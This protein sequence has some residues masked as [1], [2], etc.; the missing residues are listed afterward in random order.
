MS[1]KS[2]SKFSAR[3][4]A[5]IAI[6]AA[7]LAICSW[8]SIPTTI[9]FTMQTFGVFLTVGLLGGR[10]GTMAILLFLL[11]AAVGIPVLAGFTGGLGILLGSTGGYLLGFLLAALLLWGM[12]HFFGGSLWVLGVGMVL[13][14]TI[15]Y[16]FGT[17][18]FMAVYLQTDGPIGVLTALGWCVFPY[19]IPD[20]LKIALALALTARLRRYVK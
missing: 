13:G 1:M 14:M 6:F 9:P 15:S 20:L 3:D 5:Y 11:M 18:W 16:A 10:R 2:T 17:V 19:I 4:L 8:I 12:E 7:L